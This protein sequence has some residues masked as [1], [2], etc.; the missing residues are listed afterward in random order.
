MEFSS[1]QQA[2]DY[3]FVCGVD[4]TGAVLVADYGNKTFQVHETDDQWS[5]V[6]VDPISSHKPR[7]LLYDAD[8][9]SIWV[10][11]HH[12]L[13]FYITKLERL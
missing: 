11:K 3:P 7:D 6:S 4:F 12:G 2:M 1:S 5:V 13:S 8:T 10:L 9:D